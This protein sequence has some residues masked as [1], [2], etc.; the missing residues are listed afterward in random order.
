[1]LRSILHLV[2]LFSLG[3]N[4]A[5]AQSETEAPRVY[6][7]AVVPQ[8]EAGTLA[9]LWSPILQDISQR[10]AIQLRF[11]TAPGIPEF[12]RRLAA[13]VYDFA[14]MNSYH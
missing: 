7:F 9:R 14:Y 11:S 6:S 5:R 4:C 2:L 12:E 13:G 8:Q 3:M 1:M 10:T